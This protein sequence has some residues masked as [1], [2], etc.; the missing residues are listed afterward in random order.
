[1]TIRCFCLIYR[2]VHAC[3]DR[4]AVII[5]VIDAKV[6]ASVVLLFIMQYNLIAGIRLRDQSRK[7]VKP[8]SDL[9]LTRLRFN[10]A[11]L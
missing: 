10:A 9:K 6:N 1:M 7:P 5:D 2:R 3:S 11:A 4:I 8:E